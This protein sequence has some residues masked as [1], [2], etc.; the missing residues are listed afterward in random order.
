MDPVSFQVF[1]WVV[2]GLA[3][4]FVGVIGFMAGRMF[5][6]RDDL[7]AKVDRVQARLHKRIDEVIKDLD[8]FRLDAERRFASVDHL[9]EVEGRVGDELRGM[10]ATLHELSGA[11]NDLK[12]VI[13][14]MVKIA[15]AAGE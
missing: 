4:L 10:S 8:K 9:Q 7:E 6:L 3:V 11:I 15:A 5:K 13:A 1:A 12:I 2:G 14:P